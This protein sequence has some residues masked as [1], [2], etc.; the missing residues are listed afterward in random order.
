[1]AKLA[2][3]IMDTQETQGLS[4]ELRQDLRHYFEDIQTSS[5]SM[6]LLTA[7]YFHKITTSKNYIVY[8]HN[9]FENI[10]II[11]LINF[12]NCLFLIATLFPRF[13]F[14]FLFLIGPDLFFILFSRITSLCFF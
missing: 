8:C 13:P 10:E 4:Q 1:L 5:Y 14:S 2:M 11:P 6:D 7:K 12:K 3:G 9:N